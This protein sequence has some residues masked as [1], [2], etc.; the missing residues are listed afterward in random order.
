MAVK[1][2]KRYIKIL[3]YFCFTVINILFGK[4]YVMWEK[5]INTT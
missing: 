1:L 4:I 3:T 5:Y 2:V